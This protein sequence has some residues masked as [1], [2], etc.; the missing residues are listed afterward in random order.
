METLIERSFPSGGQ[1]PLSYA[2]LVE[3]A[4]WRA[5]DPA[6]ELTWTRARVGGITP[7]YLG[8]V[9]T[10]WAVELIVGWLDGSPAKAKMT[11]AADGTS[12]FLR[13]VTL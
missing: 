5:A 10:G 9:L 7:T 12:E 13:P 11:L 3:V 2:Q 4:L 6:G 8:E 1:Q